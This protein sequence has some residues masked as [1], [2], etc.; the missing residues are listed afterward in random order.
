MKL[1]NSLWDFTNA[2]DHFMCASAL[3]S[4]EKSLNREFLIIE[5]RISVNQNPR[6]QRVHG[7][8]VTILALYNDNSYKIYEAHKRIVKIL[9]YDNRIP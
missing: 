3:I 2:Y 5:L 8:S 9:G 7:T 4:Q 6:V 1:H